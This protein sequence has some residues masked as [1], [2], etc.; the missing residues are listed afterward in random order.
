MEWVLLIGAPIFVLF[1][2]L[3]MIIYIGQQQDRNA[4]RRDAYNPNKEHLD[5]LERIHHKDN[6][7]EW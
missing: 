3:G 5:A 6:P 4:R 1:L 7:E 2:S